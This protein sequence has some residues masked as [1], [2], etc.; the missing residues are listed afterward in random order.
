MSSSRKAALAAVVILVLVGGVLA[1]RRAAAETILV[2][3]LS[4]EARLQ[5]DPRRI[6]VERLLELALL[7]PNVS[8][9]FPPEGCPVHGDDPECDP[10]TIEGPDLP[11]AEAD[12]HEVEGM[13]ADVARLQA[14]PQ[15]DAVLRTSGARRSSISA[16]GAR[17]WSTT[18]AT[19][20]RSGP[21]ARRSS[22]P[23]RAP[24]RPPR[25]RSRG[26]RRRAIAWPATPGATAWAPR[27]AGGTART[28]WRTGRRS[29]RPTGSTR[30]WAGAADRRR[31]VRSGHYG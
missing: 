5:F 8:W 16:S 29:A 3:M 20:T 21:R 31:L 30:K 2:P 22:R 7:S 13:L 4:G 11:D 19:T 9:T 24:G 26:R 12:L 23:W 18:A 14:P 25:R 15:L 28:R 1:A 17:S 6:S 10:D 27:S